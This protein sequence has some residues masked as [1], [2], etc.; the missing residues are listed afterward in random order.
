[1]PSLATWWC[2]Q[3]RERRYVL[4]HLDELVVRRVSSS[5][6]LF[7]RGQEGLDHARHAAPRTRERLI[8]EIERNGHEFIGQEPI[9]LSLA[10][11]WSG[12]ERAARRADRC[13]ASTS[14]RRARATKSCR[15]A[16]RASPTASTRTRRG[17]SSATSARTPGCSRI[18]PSSSS[19]CSRSARR[20]SACTAAAAICRAARPTTCSG[21]A[22]T[23][24]APKAPCAC[25]A[26]S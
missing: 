23:R 13:C 26:A 17:S 3:E 11:T 20:A 5:R 12:A 19:A 18:S 4:E 22:A 14:R 9:S 25:C 7:P 8:R 16:S 6:S 1:M 10:P 15:A 21:S 2:G 24:S